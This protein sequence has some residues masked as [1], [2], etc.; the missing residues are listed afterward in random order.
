MRFGITCTKIDEVG[1]I[2]HAEN[3][4]YD[5]AWI[6]DSPLIRSNPWAVMALA[7][8]RTRRIELGTGLIIPAMRLA[9]VRLAELAEHVRVVRGL[10]AG[11]RVAYGP[12]EARHEI[13]F[14]NPELGYVELGHPIPIHLGGFGPRAQ[15]LAGELGDALVT[16]IPRGGSIPAA[17]ANV[18]QGAERA[19]RSVD[20]VEIVA[21]VN[22]L[23]LEPGEDL[24]SDRVI[25]ECGSMIMSN[26]HYLVDLHHETGAD[27]PDYVLPIWEEYLAFHAARAADTAHLDMHRS[28]YAYLDP[29]E[30]RF[31]TPEIIKS[32]C[33]A[34]RPPEVVEQLVE[35]DAQGL[36][37]INMILPLE[38]QYRLA[39]DFATQVIA[40]M[41]G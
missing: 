12:D 39:E 13:A 16:G 41:A 21:L 9:P 24:T 10:L 1:F 29:D 35:L 23:L 5:F 19:G 26:V 32:F 18:G 3:L 20:D 31:V 38:R 37:A 25:D 11:E 22:P 28:H 14:A 4:G 33:L 7:A 36:D 27:P 15:A 30:A 6:S 40:P 8:E 34:G 2:T 17:R